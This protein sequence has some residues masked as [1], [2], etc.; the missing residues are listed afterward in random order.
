MIFNMSGGGG[1][2]LNFA[3][4]GNPQ[5][6]NPKNNTVWI[7]TD[8]EITEWTFSA[9]NPYAVQ[10]DIYTEVGA[11]ADRYL[12][13]DGS[14]KV[15][16]AP[17]W[18]LTDKITLPYGT[19]TITIT[20]SSSSTSTVSHCFYDENGNLVSSVLR[21]TGTRTYLVPVGAKSVRVS[22]R[23]NDTKSVIA[24]H[25]ECD[26]GTVWIQ[27]SDSSDIEF[28][29]LKKNGIMAYPLSVKQ[30]INGVWVDKDKKIYNDGNFG[31]WWDGKLY[32]YGKEWSHITGNLTF[33]G[34][35]DCSISKGASSF[36]INSWNGDWG[37][38]AVSCVA[39]FANPIDL[40]NFN[41]LVFEGSFSR[42]GDNP[43]NG[44]GVWSNTTSPNWTNCAAS[45]SA[46]TN[47]ISTLDVSTLTG[48]YYCGVWAYYTGTSV[49][50]KLLKLE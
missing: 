11:T 4:V 32:E 43:W 6:T 13:S 38:E 8:N 48:K 44:I 20:A 40:T 19:D 49:T 30:I 22:I 29:A 35:E 37:T 33:K 15:Q 46:L 36:S 18:T 47:G 27:T 26:E 16:A 28:N 14:E 12:V 24:H 41:T 9:E 21:Q 2:G 17:H 5:P 25:Y 10:T 23:E 3:V 31:E 50:C 7:D 34:D 1:T 39:Y 45:S 42:G